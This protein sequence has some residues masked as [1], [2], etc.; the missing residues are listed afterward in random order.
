MREG[1]KKDERRKEEEAGKIE[2]RVSGRDEACTDRAVRGFITPW[3]RSSWILS[4]NGRDVAS[5]PKQR[6]SL[7]PIS[8]SVFFSFSRTPEDRLGHIFISNEM[9][10]LRTSRGYYK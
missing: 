7:Y 1:N 3:S 5:G 2:W 4:T 8:L 6:A 9:R 10:K